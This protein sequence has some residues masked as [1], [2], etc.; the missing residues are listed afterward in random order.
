LLWCAGK[1]E[2]LRG[3]PHALHSRRQGVPGPRHAQPRRGARRRSE[4]LVE[5]DLVAA[6]A[7]AHDRVGRHPAPP[8]CSEVLVEGDLVAARV[9]A[10]AGHDARL[11]VVAHAL[12]EEVGL[13]PARP[14]APV[15]APSAHGRVATL[16]PAAVRVSAP[17]PSRELSTETACEQDRTSPA[18]RLATGAPAWASPSADTEAPLG[19]RPEQCCID[20]GRALCSIGCITLWRSARAGAHCSDSISIQSNGLVAA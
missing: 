9:G 13:A 11:L 8:H 3:G 1:Q 10:Q 18:V 12:L 4:V 17:R 19:R 2:T 16:D 5:G 15:A 20:A 7:G 14:R 6:R